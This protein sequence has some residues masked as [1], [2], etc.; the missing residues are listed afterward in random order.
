MQGTA[1]SRNKR[2]LGGLVAGIAAKRRV[3]LLGRAGAVLGLCSLLACDK[4]RT[5]GTDPSAGAVVLGDAAPAAGPSSAP[6]EPGA[7]GVAWDDKTF[8][9]RQE[10]MS[11]VFLPA[12]R[13]AF[14]EHDAIAFQNF[15]CQTC[16]G[17]DMTA[18]NFAMPTEGLFPLD[19]ERPIESAMEYDEAVTK[20]MIERVVPEAAELLDAQPYDPETG[21]GF[22]CFGCHPRG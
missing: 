5:P 4:Q 6:V 11:I 12:M 14:Q 18:R 17:E 15:R 2:G 13:D 3:Q 22:G 10:W 7:P 21:R 8:A 16:H 9:Q 19:A 20:F 1:R